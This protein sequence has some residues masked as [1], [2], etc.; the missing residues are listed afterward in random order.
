[1][2]TH[3]L[4]IV[5]AFKSFLGRRL[6]EALAIEFSLVKPLSRSTGAV[7]PGSGALPAR[8]PGLFPFLGADPRGGLGMVRRLVGLGPF[9]DVRA[10]QVLKFRRQFLYYL[11]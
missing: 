3:Q 2:R 9:F 7:G 11:I 6:S 5:V 1:M 4:P 8:H 10:F